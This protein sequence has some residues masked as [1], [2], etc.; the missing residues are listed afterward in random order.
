MVEN[1]TNQTCASCDESV[2]QIYNGM[3]YC[4]WLHCEVFAAS[5]QCPHGA[6]LRELF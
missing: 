1:E 6:L 4:C 5:L 3:I 2:G